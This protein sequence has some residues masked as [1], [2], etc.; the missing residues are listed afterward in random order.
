MVFLQATLQSGGVTGGKEHCSESGR[1]EC[2]CCSWCYSQWVLTK[3]LNLWASR[4]FTCHMIILHTVVCLFTI[5]IIEKQKEEILC[6]TKSQ[7]KKQL[8]RLSSEW[9]LGGH[10]F[11]AAWRISAHIHLSADAA[12]EFWMHQFFKLHWAVFHGCD[13]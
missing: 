12:S 13:P 9:P 1:P 4:F 7:A 5:S 2:W 11:I 8:L 6:S 10:L 3:S